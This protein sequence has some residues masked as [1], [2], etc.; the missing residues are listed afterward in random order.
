MPR[1]TKE[2]RDARDALVLQ[3]FLAGRSYRL[4]GKHTRLSVGMVHR[5]IKTQMRAA[6]ARRDYIQE[7]A[8]DV[9]VERLEHLYAKAYARA[10]DDTLKPGDQMKALELCRRFLDQLGRVQDVGGD[11]MPTMPQPPEGDGLD[12]D[13]DPDDELTAWRRSHGA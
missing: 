12:E 7:N 5:I 9:Y 1:A 2:E 11:V 8:F 3:L 4:I 10:T 13:D 6:A